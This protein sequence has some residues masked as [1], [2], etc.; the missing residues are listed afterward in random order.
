[1]RG[2][3]SGARA[4]PAPSPERLTARSAP[5]NR[6]QRSAAWRGGL[7]A[8]EPQQRVS[9]GSEGLEKGFAGKLGSG[10]EGLNSSPGLYSLCITFGCRGRP[11]C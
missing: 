7:P 3:G 5:H 8:A 10:L 6:V 11:S 1:M 4:L 2:A 9:P